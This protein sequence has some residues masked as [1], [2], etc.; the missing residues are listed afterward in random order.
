MHPNPDRGGPDE[1]QRHQEH[2]AGDVAGVTLALVV[3]VLV[4]LVLVVF[5]ARI[6]TLAGPF[7]RV[8]TL[9]VPGWRCA[10]ARARRMT[11]AD[12][13]GR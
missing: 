8:G 4:T 6:P 9:V 7:L 11:V 2:A 13:F 10:I 5:M 3:V 12:I 1:A